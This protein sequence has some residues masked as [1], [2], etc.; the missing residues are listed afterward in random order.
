MK[1]AA[2]RTISSFVLATGLAAC[3]EDTRGNDGATDIEVSAE[4]EQSMCDILT[5]PVGTGPIP[6]LAG[7]DMESASAINAQPGRKPITL[8]DFDGQHGGYVRLSIDPTSY[9]PVFLMFDEAMPFEVV[10]EDG[11]VVEFHEA[12]DSSDLCPAAGGRYAWS[13]HESPNYLVFGPTDNVDFYLVLE[14]V[15]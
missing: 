10:R 13:V 15:D 8:T 6:A 3:G 4:Q 9:T 12:A 11:E 14:T 7:A 2:I 5:E 1:T